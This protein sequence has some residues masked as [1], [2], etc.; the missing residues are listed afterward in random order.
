MLT[1]NHF[2]RSSPDK[3]FLT[4]RQTGGQTARQTDAQLDGQT[5]GQTDRRTDGQPDRR[6]DDPGLCNTLGH[7]NMAEGKNHFISASS[8]RGKMLSQMLENTSI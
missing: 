6:T 5:D 3:I 4:D 7:V 1:M 8:G 2:R